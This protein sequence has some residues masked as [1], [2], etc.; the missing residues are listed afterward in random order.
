MQL[1][2]FAD[3]CSGSPTDGEIT[4]E[5]ASRAIASRCPDTRRMCAL[6]EGGGFIQAVSAAC[7]EITLAQGRKVETCCPGRLQN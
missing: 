4:A 7:G 6:V 1:D 5:S 3:T 2:A